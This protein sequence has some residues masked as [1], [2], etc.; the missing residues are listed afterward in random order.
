[1][2]LAPPPALF[3]NQASLRYAGEILFSDLQFKLPAGEITCLLGPSGIG[4]SSLL[5]LIAGLTVQE[6]LTQQ[7]AKIIA[8]DN[9]PLTN[10]ISYMAQRDLLLPWQTVL[11]NVVLGYR[12]RTEKNIASRL[13]QA[14]ALLIEMG[15]ADAMTKYPAQLSG[16]MRQRVAL[17]RTLMEEHPIVLMDEP[18]SALDTITRWRLQDL[19]AKLLAQRTVLLVTH[20][21]LEA[22]RL[23]QQILVMTG[24]PA[25]L[26]HSLV[27]PGNP[28][29]A[30]TDPL[31]LEAQARLM[32][33]LVDAAGINT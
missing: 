1:M 32:Q 20:D 25:Q 5:R 2:K 12:L 6:S 18:F 13:K 4:K 28:P 16:G 33:K 24:K 17:A 11:N 8:S 19:A 9:K 15:L 3:I 31:V 23:G 7:T 14:R 26:D 29:R 21:P 30:I 27:V 22:V 10:R